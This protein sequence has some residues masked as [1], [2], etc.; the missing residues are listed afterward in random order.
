MIIEIRNEKIKMEN[1]TEEKIIK[2]DNTMIIILGTAFYKGKLLKKLEKN[3]LKKLINCN[4]N[5]QYIKEI[6]GNYG[7]IIIDDKKINMFVDNNNIYKLYYYLDN[8]TGTF[9][10]SDLVYDIGKKNKN[11]KINQ[12]NFLEFSFQASILCNETIFDEVY[13]IDGREVIYYNLDKNNIL[14]KNKKIQINKKYLTE[15]EMSIL[16]K[17]MSLN[18]KE[19]FNNIALNMTGGIDSRIILASFLSVGIKPTLLYG[20]GN[21][22]ITNTRMEDFEIVKEISKKYNLEL[23]VMNWN[24]NFEDWDH[25]IKKYG[26]YFCIYGGSKNVFEE[27]KYLVQKYDFIEFGLFGETFRNLDFMDNEKEKKINSKKLIDTYMNKLEVNKNENEILIKYK[28]NLE[29]KLKRIARIEKI[30]IEKEID[31]YDYLKIYRYYR[32]SGDSVMCNLINKMGG[33]S[34]SILSTFKIQ[35][36]ISNVPIRYKENYKY[37]INLLKELEPSILNI[38]IFSHCA[39]R[40][41]NREYNKVELYEKGGRIYKFLKTI[42]N[43]YFSEYD[44][45]KLKKVLCKLRKKEEKYIKDEEKAREIFNEIFFKKIEEY[46][47]KF[48]FKKIV[49][50]KKF[51]EVNKRDLMRYYQ[52]LYLLDKTIG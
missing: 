1:L 31:F 6:D 12:L 11:L 9:F 8:E 23:Y 4:E 46:E 51:K 3:F 16:L 29:K 40:Y 35:N 17:E 24:D 21:S 28:N 13:S 42:K 20:I 10:I 52:T 45:F 49:C 36:Y 41:Y 2:F 22:I 50:L 47:M 38:P 48:F 19:N 34:M 30:K 43:E 25:L 14:K 44:L 5:E 27:Y 32:Y 39:M 33:N 18:I 26:E 7:I 37:I 15:K